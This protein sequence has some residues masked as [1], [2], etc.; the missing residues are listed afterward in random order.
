MAISVRNVFT[1]AAIIFE[2]EH[3]TTEREYSVSVSVGYAY[4]ADHSV[5][6][7]ELFSRADS[8]MYT[9]KRLQSN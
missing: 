4:R 2:Q 6:M 3:N 8:M 9:D 7:A 1:I 5:S